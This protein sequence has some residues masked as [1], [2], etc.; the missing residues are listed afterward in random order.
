[1][2]IGKLKYN[3][4][5]NLYLKLIKYEISKN[6]DTYKKLIKNILSLYTKEQIDN[7]INSIVISG[8]NIFCPTSGINGRILR[9]LEYGTNNT[10]A[11]HIITIS[12]DKVLKEVKGYESI[13]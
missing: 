11:Y 2:I 12:T 3:I 8:N 4:N 13:I 9:S 10:K 6:I 7:A 1:M 5:R